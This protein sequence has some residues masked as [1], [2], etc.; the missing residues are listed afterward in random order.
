MCRVVVGTLL[1]VGRGRM[2]PTDVSNILTQRV[3]S[4]AGVSVEP[5]GLML[6]E[7]HYDDQGVYCPEVGSRMS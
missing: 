4:Q 2:T 5:H 3:R 1:E 7:V 6:K